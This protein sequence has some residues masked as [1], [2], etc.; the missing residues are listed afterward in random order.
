MPKKSL[1]DNRQ[2]RLTIIALAATIVLLAS[3][4]YLAWP[5]LSALEDLDS[6]KELI[7]NAGPWGPVIF[8]ALQAAQVVF[9]PLPGHI[10]GFVGG[11]LF[12]TWW[13]VV[14]SII[15]TTVG[16]AIVFVLARQLGRPLVEHFVSDKNLKKFDY[17]AHTKGAWILFV[18]FLL[19]A[20]PEAVLGYIAGLSPVRIRLLLM[21][22]VLGRLP[23]VIML[24]YAG[25]ETANANYVFVS[26]LIVTFV[27]V[28]GVA[29]LKRD[30]LERFA[31][32][33]ATKK[34]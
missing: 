7:E 13:G 2:L 17:L 16:F 24:S 26:V 3:L 8:A 28:A 19:P 30:K 12:G 10:A 4:A 9:A 18:L 29:Y 11:L 6:A 27:I 5:Y 32:R 21:V 15:G 20:I 23:G 22:S 31:E 33:L 25:G 14:Y 34:K 1:W